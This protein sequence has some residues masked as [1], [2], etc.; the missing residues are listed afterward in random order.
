MI[1]ECG[2]KLR[3]HAKHLGLCCRVAFCG[4]KNFV[5]KGGHC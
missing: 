3:A 4:C 2:H 1:C 5:A